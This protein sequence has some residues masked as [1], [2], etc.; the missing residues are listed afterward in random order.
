MGDRQHLRQHQLAWRGERVH[1]K[2]ENIPYFFEVHQRREVSTKIG[3]TENH[4]QCVFPMGERRCGDWVVKEGKLSDWQ[5]GYP[6]SDHAGEVQTGRRREGYE[7]SEG[8]KLQQYFRL[9]HGDWA[10]LT[11][12]CYIEIEVH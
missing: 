7:N 9:R 5:F 2:I 6:H 3:F 10:R 1:C 4:S 12:I 8:D 11:Q